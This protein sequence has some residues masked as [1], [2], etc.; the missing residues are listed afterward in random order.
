MTNLKCSICGQPVEFE[1]EDLGTQLSAIALQEYLEE[2]PG[3]NSYLI[4]EDCDPKD[5]P[6]QP[7]Y[8]EIGGLN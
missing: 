4:C 3:R 7:F 1:A 2:N 8:P 6:M 5:L